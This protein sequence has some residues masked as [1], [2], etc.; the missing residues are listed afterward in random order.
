MRFIV[1]FTIVLFCP[2]SSNTKHQ[3]VRGNNGHGTSNSE[4]PDGSQAGGTTDA[5]PGDGTV[6]D[7]CASGLSCRDVIIIG[8][9]WAGIG[10]ALQIDNYNQN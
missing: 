8:A 6:V 9:G 5:D 7:E 10:A 1:V 4:N 2:L 3:N